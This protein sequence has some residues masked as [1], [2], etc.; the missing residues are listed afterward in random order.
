MPR[1]SGANRNDLAVLGGVR[2]A[3]GS[4]EREV[5]LAMIDARGCTKRITL[6]ADK[7]YDVTKFVHDLRDRL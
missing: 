6:G 4:A 5:A 7:A 2:Q 3:T 1:A